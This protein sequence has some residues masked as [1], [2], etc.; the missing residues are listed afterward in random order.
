MCDFSIRFKLRAEYG[1]K[2]GH[3]CHRAVMWMVVWLYLCNIHVRV[4]L[5]AVYGGKVGHPCHRAA[6]M[7]VVW[8]YLCDIHVSQTASSV[9]GKVGYCD[10]GCKSARLSIGC[11]L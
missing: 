5:R 11:E 10:G 7:L 4:E 6:T 1:G 9:W 2:V 8:L 3:P